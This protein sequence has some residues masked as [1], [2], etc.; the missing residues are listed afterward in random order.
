MYAWDTEVFMSLNRIL[1]AGLAATT[2]LTLILNWNEYLFAV[3]LALS[4]IHI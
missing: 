1:I 2:L 4:L 3:F